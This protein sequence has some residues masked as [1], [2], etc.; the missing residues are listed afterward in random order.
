MLAHWVFTIM[1]LISLGVDIVPVKRK[2]SSSEGLDDRGKLS[3][4]PSVPLYYGRQLAQIHGTTGTP[5][6]VILGTTLR[7]EAPG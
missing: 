7:G 1:I 6:R 2:A 3:S 4:K 5:G